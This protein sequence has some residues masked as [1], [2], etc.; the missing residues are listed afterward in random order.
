MTDSEHPHEDFRDNPE[1]Q[2]AR[3]EYLFPDS[4]DP[5]TKMFIRF[6]AVQRMHELEPDTGQP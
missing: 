2:L 5:D 6:R 3:A 4:S 1:W